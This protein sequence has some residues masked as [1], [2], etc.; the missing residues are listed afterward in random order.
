MRRR[1]R[2]GLGE[3]ESSRREPDSVSP[4]RRAATKSSSVSKR[5]RDCV[6]YRT[7][8]V[9]LRPLR[10]YRVPLCDGRFSCAC[11]GPRTPAPRVLHPKCPRSLPPQHLLP[12]LLPPPGGGGAELVKLLIG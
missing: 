6:A 11:D 1:A 4:I 7:H 8:R 10:E 5:P 12:P 2:A 9:R 3:S